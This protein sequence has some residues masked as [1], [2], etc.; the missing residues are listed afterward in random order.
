[1]FGIKEDVLNYIVAIIKVQPIL[2]DHGFGVQLN[3][4]SGHPSGVILT[5]DHGYCYFQIVKQRGDLVQ[6]S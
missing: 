5:L 6:Q 1:M 2:D 3:W 4:A